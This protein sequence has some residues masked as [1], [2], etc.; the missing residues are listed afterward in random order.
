MA[1][2]LEGGCGHPGNSS[3]SAEAVFDGETGGPTFGASFRVG[4]GRSLYVGV[5]GRFF[6]K[7]GERVF[8]ADAGSDPSRSDIP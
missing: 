7:D 2:G 3:R 4:I 6:S 8:V 5:T 1:L